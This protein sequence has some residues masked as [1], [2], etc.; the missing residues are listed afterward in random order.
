MESKDILVNGLSGLVNIGNTCYMNASLQCLCANNLFISYLIKKKFVTPL[1]DNIVDKLGEAERSKRRKLN[2]DPVDD[3]ISIYIKD[4]KKE[5][6][7]SL[8]YAIYKLFKTMWKG[9]TRVTPKTFKHRLGEVSNTFMGFK[10][11]DAHEFINCI[12][13]RIHEETKMDVIIQYI[14]MPKE[15]SNYI[16]KRKE[17]LEKISAEILDISYYNTFIKSHQR[18]ETIYK[19]LE[20]WSGYVKKN[21]SIIIDLFTGLFSS[22]IICSVCNNKSI[23]FEPFNILPLS[24]PYTKDKL[25]TLDDCLDNFSK[26]EILT[27]DNAYKCECCNNYV[28]ATKNMYLWDLPELLVIQLK[29]FSNIGKKTMKNDVMIKFPF[30]NLTFEKNYHEFRKRD[31]SYDLYGVVYHMGNLNGGHYIAFTKNLIN[32]KWYRFDDSTVSHIPDEYIENELYKDGSYILF[33]K[34]K[35]NQTDLTDL[36]DLTEEE[37]IELDFT[38]EEDV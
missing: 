34:K 6:Y 10:H 36:T 1:C 29:R 33:Y 32:R 11:Q 23:N 38:S 12:L 27:G 8:V 14:N 30:E 17:L 2:K 21:H 15:I 4:V 31:Y 24:I 16:T 28:D 9:N 35:I 3:D 5:Y 19:S 7:T 25:I 26:S 37:K 20:Y 22:E 13:D 18:E